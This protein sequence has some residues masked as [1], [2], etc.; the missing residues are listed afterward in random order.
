MANQDKKAE[1]WKEAKV[2]YTDGKTINRLS[3]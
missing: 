3:V 2:R 1:R